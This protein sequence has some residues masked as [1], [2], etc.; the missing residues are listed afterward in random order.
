M[1]FRKKRRIFTLDTYK[2]NASLK[3]DLASVEAVLVDGTVLKIFTT[4]SCHEFL[5]NTDHNAMEQYK[6][7][8]HMWET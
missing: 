6:D 1:F 7:L 2:D 4:H 8:I 5:F 3:I